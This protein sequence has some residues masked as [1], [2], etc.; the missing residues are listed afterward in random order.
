MERKKIMNL[1]ERLLTLVKNDH[2]LLNVI[3]ILRQ[4]HLREATIVGDPIRN[5]IWNAITKQPSSVLWDKITVYYRNISE[6]YED[7]LTTQAQLSQNHSQYFWELTNLSLPERAALAPSQLSISEAVA[8]QPEKCSAVGI[9]L[10]SGGELTVIA[11]YGLDDA[12]ALRVAPTPA[13][14]VGT[15]QHPKYQRRLHFNHWQERWPDL[16]IG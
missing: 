14:A 9:Q 7:F 8:A 6:S 1:E 3:T 2:H 15:K 10:L 16:T 5:L 11:P 4:Q 12:F 13:F